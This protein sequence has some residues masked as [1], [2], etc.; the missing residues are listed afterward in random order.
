LSAEFA[1]VKVAGLFEGEN[2]FFLSYLH[3]EFEDYM[4][5]GVAPSPPGTGKMPVPQIEIM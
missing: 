1:G 2:E 4:A 5:W 3:S